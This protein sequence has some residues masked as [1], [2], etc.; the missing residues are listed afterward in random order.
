MEKPSRDAEEGYYKII[1]FNQTIWVL[2]VNEILYP[3]ATNSMLRN[4]S[5]YGFQ[6]ITINPVILFRIVLPFLTF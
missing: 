6:L 5:I 1:F 2:F 4:S 3:K